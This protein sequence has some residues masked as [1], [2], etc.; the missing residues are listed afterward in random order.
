[1]K[2]EAKFF[3]AYVVTEPYKGCGHCG[4]GPGAFV[5]NDAARRQAG[6]GAPAEVAPLVHPG[7]YRHYKGGLYRVLLLA[8][9]STNRA[10]VRG[11]ELVVDSTEAPVVVYISLETGNVCVRDLRQWSEWVSEAGKRRFERVES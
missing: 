6:D 10:D 9:D 4:V 5:H 8:Q 2:D 7:M 1:M 3:H 11:G